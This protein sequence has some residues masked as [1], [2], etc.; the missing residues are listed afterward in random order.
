MTMS[1]DIGTRRELFVDGFLIES[2]RG[3]RLQLAHPERRE[4]VFEADAPWEDFAFAGL[5]VVQEGAG[6]R[7][8]YRA[9]IPDLSDEKVCIIAVAESTDGGRSFTRPRLGMYEFKGSKDN[10]IVW[11]G[12]MPGVPPAFV[13][14][15]PDCPAEGRYKGLTGEWRKLYAMC[16]QDGIRWRLAQKDPV[17]M[18]GTFDTVN[19]AFWDRTSGCYRCYTRFFDPSHKPTKDSI[20]VRAIQTATSPDFVNWTLPIPLV[21][22]DGDATMQMYTNDIIPCPGAEHIYIGFPNRIVEER[23]KFPPQRWPGVNDAIFMASRDGVRWSRYR[24]AWVRPGLDRRNWTHRNNYPVWHIIETSP[25][26]WSILISEHYMQEDGTPGRLR[27]LSVRPWGFISAHCDFDGGEIV[28]RP[29]VFAGRRLRLNY[30]TSAAGAI[31]VEV[32]D[33]TGHPLPGL[34]LDEMAPM[35][36]DELDAAVVWR[37]GSDLGRIAGRAVRLRFVLRD[38]DLYALRLAEDE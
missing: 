14:A 31:Q 6:I 26:E 30:S 11:H 25:E 21:Y 5:S 10:N 2:M 17:E 20:G 1:V 28:T 27:R 3:G 33:V 35:F 34:G 9:A 18:P 23:V 22:E 12:G 13:D 15:R 36:G 38:A 8:Y 4:I 16:S 19:T 7:L 24:E 32:Q 37:K 29:L